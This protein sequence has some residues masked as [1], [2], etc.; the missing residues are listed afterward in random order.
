M[1]QSCAGRAEKLPRQTCLHLTSGINKPSWWPASSISVK[2][3]TFGHLSGFFSLCIRS[4]WI[5]QTCLGSSKGTRGLFLRANVL[6][7]PPAWRCLLLWAF[8]RYSGPVWNKNQPFTLK[9]S[10]RLMSIFNRKGTQRFVRPKT[11]FLF[12]FCLSMLSSLFWLLICTVI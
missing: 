4:I 12:A 1:L 10:Q 3:C 9:R 6:S 8:W 5:W 2:K 11:G 7:A